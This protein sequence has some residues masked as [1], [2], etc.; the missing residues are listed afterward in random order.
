[1][2]TSNPNGSLLGSRRAHIPS[3][4]PPSARMSSRSTPRRL[5][6]AA[7]CTWAT[8]SP[9]PTPTRSLGS[10]ACVARA[11]STPWVGMTTACPPSVAFRITSGCHA[12]LRFPMFPIC[13]RHSVVIRQRITNQFLCHVRTSSS[14]AKSSPLKTKRFS[15]ISSVNW[16][17]QLIGLFFTQRLMSVL[18]VL[19]SVRS[20]A[21]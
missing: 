20:F 4:A 6:S 9:I 1:M 2:T 15:K 5:P 16:D 7:L 21:T 17:S 14:C 8:C 11:F 18:V 10:G 19:V 3:I 12:M 13:S